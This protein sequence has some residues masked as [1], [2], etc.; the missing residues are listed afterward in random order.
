MDILKPDLLEQLLDVA[1]SCLEVMPDPDHQC[2]KDLLLFPTELIIPKVIDKLQGTKVLQVLRRGHLG[3]AFQSHSFGFFIQ[4]L[5]VQ[6]FCQSGHAQAVVRGQ[7]VLKVGRAGLKQLGVLQHGGRLQQAKDIL[8]G[9][10]NLPRVNIKYNLIQNL[11]IDAL[12]DDF[13]LATFSE[14]ITEHCLEVWTAGSQH[15]SVAGDFKAPRAEG[16]I[17]QHPALPQSIQLPQQFGGEVLVF[18]EKLLSGSFLHSKIG[19]R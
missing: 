4:A 16:D 7:L 10:K 14:V 13:S 8:S 17:S 15:V 18:E 11:G 1:L 12:Q 6:D 2:L 5:A 3:K 19:E 9:Y